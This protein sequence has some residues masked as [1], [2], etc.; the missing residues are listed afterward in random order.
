M[1]SFASVLIITF[2]IDVST[3]SKNTLHLDILL[4]IVIIIII[5]CNIVVEWKMHL[6]PGITWTVP[7]R[8]VVACG[9]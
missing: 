8:L 4:V 3:H 5:N 6:S 7:L 9:S 2:M 1:C